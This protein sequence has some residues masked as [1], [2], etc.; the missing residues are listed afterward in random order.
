MSDT[1][2]TI[3][4]IPKLENSENYEFLRQAG[5][6]YIQKLS[7]RIW[8]D[9]NRHDPGISIHEL[10]CYAITDL[11][12]RT[13]FGIPDL[14]AVDKNVKPVDELADFFTAAE[15]LPVNP[16]SEIDIR[17][18]I[19]DT[20]GVKNAWLI[21]AKDSEYPV[22][23]DH[24]NC[25]LTL[26][27]E[28]GDKLIPLQGLY[29]VLLEYEL[30]DKGKEF[31][32]AI[33]TEV[34]AALM[35]HRN[36]CE[37][38]LSITAVGYEDIAVCSDIEVR[39]DVDID[40]VQAKIY[41]ILI[42]YFSPSLN[43]YT[44]PEMLEGEADKKDA[45]TGEVL[46]W[47]RA[48]KTMDQIFEGPLL[49]HG[50]ID[51]DELATAD[52]RTELHIS[53]VIN[54]IMDIDG[55]IA[56]K[57]IS[58]LKYH[59]DEFII[60]DDWVIALEKL[61]APR[62][63]R[64]KSKFIFYKGILPY[65]AHKENVDHELREL[66]QKNEAFRKSGHERDLPVPQGEFRSLTDYFPVQNDFPL[67]YGIGEIGLSGS[68]DDKRMAQ[69]KQLKAYLLLFEQ[70]LT[71]Y[72]AQLANLKKLF[73]SMRSVTKLP[74]KT[75][76]YDNEK[77]RTYF[78]Q[79]LKEIRMFQEKEVI[80]QLLTSTDRKE[81]EKFRNQLIDR[82]DHK[83]LILIEWMT[84]TDPVRIAAWR[85]QLNTFFANGEYDL[86][87]LETQRSVDPAG[88]AAAKTAVIATIY[89]NVKDEITGVHYAKVLNELAE[90]EDVFIDRRNRFLDHLMARFCENMTDYSLIVH[91]M[92]KDDQAAGLRMIGDKETFLSDYPIFSRDR[93]K[94]FN[95]KY[96]HPPW[97][98]PMHVSNGIW[99]TDNVSG[100]K[101]RIVRLLGMDEYKRRTLAT[102]L[103]NIKIK[104]VSGEPTWHVELSDPLDTA[105]VLMN[106]LDYD[107]E[108]CAESTLLYML[109]EGDN[110]DKY[111]IKGTAGAYYYVLNNDCEDVE[112]VATSKK[113]FV[114][115][116]VC[117]AEMQRVIQFFRD[118]CDVESFHLVEHILLRPR[119]N[120]DIP[121]PNCVT[122]PKEATPVTADNI[123]TYMFHIRLLTE[124]EKTKSIKHPKQKQP[125]R[126]KFELHDQDGHIILNSEGYA[127]LNGCTNGIASLR[128][129]GTS[130]P[131][132]HLSKSKTFHGFSL[133]ADN[134]EMI[135]KSKNYSTTAKRDIEIDA[136]IKFL[137]FK[138][139]TWNVADED[140]FFCNEEDDPYSFQ[141][142]VILPA[143][144]T[145]FRNI[146]FRQF[147]ERTIR[148]ETPAHIHPKICW[149]NLDQMR[150]FERAYHKWVGGMITNDIPNPH[151]SRK[152]IKALYSLDNVYPAALLHSCDDTKS[153]EPQVIL[154]YT[155]LG[156]L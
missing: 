42:D 36:L 146:A 118:N 59:D 18:L 155:S 45:V 88:F 12:Y 47:K 8:T 152:L 51:D 99:N 127:Q 89:D 112:V 154:D 43:F 114:K 74:D 72:L 148:L 92:M 120:L 69:A 38:V 24:K 77:N 111:E 130:K 153:N 53:D 63:S 101:H 108:E 23:Y 28:K 150:K 86:T 121:L 49:K 29:N 136:L 124:E 107:T 122:C 100:M 21:T 52:L 135:A 44:L 104:M 9:Y 26:D 41:K 139:D 32:D 87:A 16:T 143:W 129:H 123:P 3:P 84:E 79:K 60:S 4:K 78:T 97:H 116:D 15:I 149:V 30:D 113:T 98:N 55:V 46:T 27:P 54:S 14:L 62:L 144:P 56:V 81:R 75:Y 85:L 50:F 119:T 134:G 115:R 6:Q 91:Q 103:L 10:M 65:M 142:S 19:I 76:A 31:Y 125:D 35:S 66:Q 110:A 61:K 156:N 141:V 83:Y 96:P 80:V 39:P 33:K 93:G 117:E 1:S 17:K 58:F 11:G 70:I 102:E 151:T 67:V 147:V 25:E 48:P 22:Y 145:R 34:R 132:Y 73:T 13:S 138:D 7:G 131:N 68:V 106:S 128:E 37:D 71:N 82:F 57:T 40:E 64:D 140:T 137:A 20:P 133:F 105:V 2:I 126:W 94:G 90:T 95:Y 5:I 109:H